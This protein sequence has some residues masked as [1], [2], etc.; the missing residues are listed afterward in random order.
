MYL[1][2]IYFADLCAK[3]I[4]NQHPI[5]YNP[6]YS[7]IKCY[8]FDQ[9]QEMLTATK[10]ETQHLIDLKNDNIIKF[11]GI[12]F[13]ADKLPI[14]V[15]ESYQCDLYEHLDTNQIISW[16][17]NFSILQGIS[18]ALSYLHAVKNVA[19]CNL[20]TKT[21]V[22]TQSFVAKLISFELATTLSC[23]ATAMENNNKLKSDDIFYFG[24]ILINIINRTQRKKHL[25][26]LFEDMH[27]L[28]ED[29]LLRKT[30]LSAS[31]IETTI[32]DHR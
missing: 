13:E 28:A 32:G 31:S 26:S 7:D 11:I 8:E 10:V 29:C 12:Y 21:V 24:E 20:S 30:S 25:F 3:H 1:T 5:G 2:Y 22:L 19:H 4:R 15:M 9:L 18:N 17:N 23:D 27:Q 14:I 6:D 16:N